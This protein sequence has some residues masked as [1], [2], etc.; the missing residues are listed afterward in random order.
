[1]A[2][3]LHETIAI[4]E[5]LIMIPFIATYIFSLVVIVRE[6][7]LFS[8]PCYKIMLLLG[9]LECS[10]VITQGLYENVLALVYFGRYQ[11]MG[12][13]VNDTTTNQMVIT[14]SHKHF[15]AYISSMWLG[16]YVIY[17]VLSFDRFL[18]VY[19][20]DWAKRVFHGSRYMVAWLLVILGVMAFTGFQF[21]MKENE[22]FYNFDLHVWVWSAT[23]SSFLA[24]FVVA[25][26]MSSCAI[27]FL[28][29]ALMALKFKHILSTARSNRSNKGKGSMMG[30]DVFA[31][32]VPPF[33]MSVM[34]SMLAIFYIYVVVQLR[35]R[36]SCR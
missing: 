23:I 28:A 22:P 19:S 35:P 27:V 10:L 31:A 13:F 17:S 8:M 14:A 5:L 24:H 16:I 21:S 32:F 36:T 25:V 33:L 1:M 15:G 4:S 18:T 34:L 26:Y 12:Q 11:D 29:H 30:A 9:F 3:S 6:Q 7:S 2:L 20:E